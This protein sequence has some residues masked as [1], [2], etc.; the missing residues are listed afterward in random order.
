MDPLKKESDTN[1]AGTLDISPTVDILKSL[2]RDKKSNQ[3][4]IGFALET[5]NGIKNAKTKL[6]AKKLD[7]IILNSAEEKSPFDSDSNQVVIINKQRR[8]TSLPRMDKKELAKEL[9]K[10][11]AKVK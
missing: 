2:S 10:R 7:L 5:E 11:I 1:K 3:K 9:I 8:Q 4:V 6:K